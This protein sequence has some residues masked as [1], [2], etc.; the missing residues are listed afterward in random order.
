MTAQIGEVLKYEGKF[1]ST[2]SIIGFPEKIYKPIEDKPVNFLIGSTACWRQYIGTWEIKD[3]K[4]YLIKI[5]GKVE[6]INSPVLA[7]WFSG[8]ITI[9]NNKLK[10]YV[11]LGFESEFK[12][13]EQIVIENGIVKTF[14]NEAK[15]LFKKR[16]K[17]KESTGQIS[18]EARK[19][20]EQLWKSLGAISVKISW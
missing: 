17:K 5:D 14:T 12:N 7:D 3:N 20:T 1:A 15:S 4:L 6:L 9:H 19:K 2:K 13:E 8:T 10:R 16:E 11:H 18:E